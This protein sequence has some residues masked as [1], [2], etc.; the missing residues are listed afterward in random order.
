MAQV[1]YC[2]EAALAGGF[3]I[4]G[5]KLTLLLT[6]VSEKLTFAINENKEKGWSSVI[7]GD[8]NLIKTFKHQGL[9]ELFYEG[10]TAKIDKKMHARIIVRLDRLEQVASI[11]ELNLPGY[12]FHSLKGFKPTRYTIH[13]NGPWCITFEIEDGD[14]YNVDFEQYH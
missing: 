11:S 9:Y 1:D 5:K 2:Y 4:V 6:D 10:A 7:L 8:G 14:V 12:D 13:V 3:F